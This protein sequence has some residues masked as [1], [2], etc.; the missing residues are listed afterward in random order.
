M[1]IKFHTGSMTFMQVFLLKDFCISSMNNQV[2]RFHSA[3]KLLFELHFGIFWVVFSILQTV[4]HFYQCHLFALH[5]LWK[6]YILYIFLTLHTSLLK[7]TFEGHSLINRENILNI[8]GLIL[9]LYFIQW[10]PWVYVCYTK[11]GYWPRAKIINIRLRC[12]CPWMEQWGSSAWR[13]GESSK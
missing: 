4:T 3:Y 11:Y 10:L 8:S 7:K 13:V 9:H 2:F 12:F 1:V 5:I 6:K